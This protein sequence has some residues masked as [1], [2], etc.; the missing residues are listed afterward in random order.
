MQANDCHSVSSG[1]LLKLFSKH[2]GQVILA[3]DSCD[4]YVT[5][6]VSERG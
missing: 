1:E 4:L 6:R 2:V 5:V 3:L